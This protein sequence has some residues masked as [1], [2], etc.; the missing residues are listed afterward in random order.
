MTPS[1]HGCEGF[2]TRE[3]CYFT[4]FEPNYAPTLLPCF[5]DPIVRSTFS[6]KIKFPRRLTCLSNMPAKASRAD[7]E[8]AETEF[9]ETPAMCAYLLAVF[10]GDFGRI[11][12][13]TLNGLPVKMYAANG[14]QD[15]LWEHL[16]GALFAVD[17]MEKKTGAKYELPHLQFVSHSGVG[18]G[19]ENYGLI[20]LKEYLE[21]S[22]FLRSLLTVFH[23][24]SH[25][26]FGDLVSVK[27]WDLVWLNEGFAQLFQYLILGDFSEEYR[28][29]GAIQLFIKRDR[30]RCLDFFDEQ[31]V[32]VAEEEVDFNERVLRTAI[33]IKG[34][35]VLKMFSDIAGAADF[36]KVCSNWI[37]LFKNR[38]GD[39]SEFVGVVNSTLGADY[40]DFFNTWLRCVGFPLLNVG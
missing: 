25:L 37:G 5:D 38:S 13:E 40:S 24:V 27:W 21:G 39:V 8:E 1:A 14:R 19:M 6:V 32:V 33:Y 2:Y 15:L 20:A 4:K 11:E 36:L 16:K 31:K 17:W 30:L 22:D 28:S 18:V 34:A 12:G 26:W 23:E 35:F 9:L 3:G 29:N 7:G 10:V